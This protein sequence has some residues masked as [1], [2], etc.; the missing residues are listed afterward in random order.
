MPGPAAQQPPGGQPAAPQRSVAFERFHGVR[1]AGRR[2]ATRRGQGRADEPAVEPHAREQE[3]GHH[4]GTPGWRLA[5]PVHD[6][7]QQRHAEDRPGDRHSHPTRSHGP[8]TRLAAEAAEPEVP[9]PAPAP[10]AGAAWL[11]G[12]D[13]PGGLGTSGGLGRAGGAPSR[14]ASAASRSWPS[15]AEAAALAAGSALTTTSAPTGSRGSRS[16]TRWRSRRITLCRWTDPPTALPTTNP[17][18]ADSAG[19]GTAAGSRCT[20]S[21]PRP[22]RRPSRTVRVK[23]CLPVN[24]AAGGSTTWPRVFVW[25]VI[26]AAVGQAESSRRPLRRR[27]PMIA[28]PARVRIRSRK[29]CVLA[30][31]RLFG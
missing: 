25:I 28:R 9:L 30:R 3:R 17:T 21:V 29:P 6:H 16:R 7:A 20:T 26:H 22:A 12:L 14:R 2:E 27:A 8:A 19:S 15:V 1:A 4:A 18:R 10:P 31:R 13:R 23:S 5:D 11:G 24:R